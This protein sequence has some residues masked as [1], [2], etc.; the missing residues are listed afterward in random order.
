MHGPSPSVNCNSSIRLLTASVVDNEPRGTSPDMSMTPAPDTP[1]TSL[2][3]SH[4]RVDVHRASPPTESSAMIRDN[5]F[6]RGLGAPTQPRLHQ[7]VRRISLSGGCA[8]GVWS[9]TVGLQMVSP[10][11]SLRFHG[12]FALG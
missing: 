4:R 1:M 9:G 2:V 5:R 11:T 10:C 7:L 3:T 8:T 12:L 6:G